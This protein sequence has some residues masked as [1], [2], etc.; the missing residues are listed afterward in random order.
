M[1]TGIVHAQATHKNML[2]LTI[3]ALVGAVTVH[4]AAL[5]VIIGARLGHWVTPDFDVN[6][7]IYTQRRLIQKLWLV[8]WLW[9]IYW[10]PYRQ[11]M[12]HRGR[13]HRWPLGTLSRFVYLLW[14][15]VTIGLHNL[16]EL[17]IPLFLYFCG[18]IFLGWTVQDW[19]HLR[20]DNF[21]PYNIG[22]RHRAS[23]RGF[24]HPK[25]HYK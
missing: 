21:F 10:W 6:H 11:L 18:A 9:V 16:P 4:P 8:G 5:G 24:K 13:S 1:S 3:A 22:F 17:Y 19:S 12:S 20:L 14:L 7:P 25:P 2:P 15:P 23:V